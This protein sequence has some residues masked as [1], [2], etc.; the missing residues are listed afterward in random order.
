MLQGQAAVAPG[1]PDIVFA[2][3]HTSLVARSRLHPRTRQTVIRGAAA[4]LAPLAMPRLGADAAV[5]LFD[6][7]DNMRPRHDVMDLIST[8]LTMP[9]AYTVQL[10]RNAAQCGAI[11]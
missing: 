3:L 11:L 10:W 1:E 6:R 2:A 7:S 4:A 8:T 5:Y 9:L